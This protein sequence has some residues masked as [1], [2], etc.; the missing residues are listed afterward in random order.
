MSM[1]QSLGVQDWRA[2]ACLAPGGERLLCVGESSSQVRAAYAGAW[3]EVIRDEDRRNRKKM[4]RRIE[5]REKQRSLREELLERDQPVTHRPDCSTVV[6]NEIVVDRG[7]SATMTTAE[8]YANDE[9]LTSIAADG[10]CVATPTGSTAYSLAAGGSLC[11][12]ALPGMLITV[13]C[14]HSLTFRPI[15]LPDNIVLRI[16]VPYDARTSSWVSFDGRRRT[17]LNQGDYI[18]IVTSQY[19]LPTVQYRMDNKDWFDSIK[20]TMNW[21]DRITQKSIV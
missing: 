15:L 18:T 9:F 14:A 10:L 8:L 17:E 19:P 2:V 4:K 6:L 13:I 1:S 21:G 5:E 12:P 11:H 3:G 7:P 16:G 20:R